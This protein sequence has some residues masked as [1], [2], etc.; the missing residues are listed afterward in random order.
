MTKFIRKLEV[1]LGKKGIAT[2][3]KGPSI[4]LGNRI[5]QFGGHGGGS[6]RYQTT[7]NWYFVVGNARP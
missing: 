6:K 4:T 2:V 1:I 7:F 5:R 3:E